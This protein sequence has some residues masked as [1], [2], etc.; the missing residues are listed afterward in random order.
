VMGPDSVE[1]HTRH[2]RPFTV[3]APGLVRQRTAPTRPT[4]WAV[5]GSEGL[6]VGQERRPVIDGTAVQLPLAGDH[7]LGR[8]TP[9]P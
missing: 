7:R 5:K 9:F 8:R 1:D 3:S 6:G 4:A 2:H